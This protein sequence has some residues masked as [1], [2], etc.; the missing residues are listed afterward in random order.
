LESVVE[1]AASDADENHP[2][3]YTL[4]AGSVLIPRTSSSPVPVTMFAQTND[5]SEVF[6]FATVPSDLLVPAG[7]SDATESKATVTAPATDDDWIVPLTM[8]C[9]EL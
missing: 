7:V 3:T 2:V 6:I 1:P 5:P 4:P 8:M 9:D